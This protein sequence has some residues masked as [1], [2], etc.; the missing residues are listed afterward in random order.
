[1]AIAFSR[2]SVAEVVAGRP[3]MSMFVPTYNEETSIAAC[4]E[5]I[6]AQDYPAELIEVL[7]VDGRSEDDTIGVVERFVR[8]LKATT[9]DPVPDIRI[10]DNPQ[11]DQ[12]SAWNRAMEETTGDVIALVVAHSFLAPD[13]TSRAVA[14]LQDGNADVVGGPYR[15]VGVGAAGEA[16][17]A[18]M[19][20]RFGVGQS[21]Y[22]WGGDVEDIDSLANA[23]YPVPLLK[24]FMPFDSSIGK[25]IGQDWDIHFRMREEGVRLGQYSDIKHEFHARSSLSRLWTQ[26]FKYATTKVDVMRKHGLKAL[27]ATHFI[28]LLFVLWILIGAGVAAAVPG[29]R[30]VWLGA[31]ALYGVCDLVASLATAAKHGLR[32]FPLLFVSFLCMHLSYG[33]GMLWGLLQGRWLRAVD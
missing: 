26:Q 21:R 6:V 19:S 28:P 31:L 33:I 7:V 10:I 24:R 22:R 2:E 32:L 4:L 30:A 29:F 8:E 20:S 14:R 9:S 11:R 17:A 27:R 15:M 3:R 23:I 12:A 16:I 25:G 13:F 1:M 5:T 18:A